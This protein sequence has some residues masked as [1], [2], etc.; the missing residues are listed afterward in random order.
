MPFVAAIVECGRWDLARI[1]SLCSVGRAGLELQRTP[2]ETQTKIRKTTIEPSTVFS[3]QTLS[4]SSSKFPIKKKR[5]C[6]ER[7]KERCVD[8][9]QGAGLL[10]LTKDIPTPRVVVVVILTSPRLAVSRDRMG[11]QVTF[12]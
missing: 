12:G 1:C 8:P 11:S 10:R 7:E 5:H 4:F 6:P 9:P 2:R 3:E